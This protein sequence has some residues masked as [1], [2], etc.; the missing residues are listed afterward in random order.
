MSVG[1]LIAVLIGAPAVAIVGCLLA[2]GPRIAEALNLIA[3]AVA[4]CCALPLAEV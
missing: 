3:S 1:I 4:F 2:R